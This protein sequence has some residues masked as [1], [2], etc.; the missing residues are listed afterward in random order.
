ME[1]DAIVVG[2]GPN[3][4]AAATELASAG[5]SVA[6]F[7]A[8]DTVGGGARSAE[9][10]LPGFTHDVCSAIHPLGVASPFFKS[11][12]LEQLGVEWIYPEFPVAHP[13]DNGEAAI[14]RRSVKET[15]E[16]L[17]EDRA[18]YVRLFEPMTAHAGVIMEEVLAPMHVPR[19]P[20]I[21]ASF[22]R[23]AVRAATELARAY[24]KGRQS[25]ALFAGLAAHAQMPLDRRP[26]AAY[27]LLLGMLGHSV[28][29]PLP[30][31]GSQQISNALAS[32]I[33]GLGGKVFTARPIES[34]D[35]LPPARAILC[36]ITPRQLIRIAGDRLD[37]SYSRKLLRYRYGPGV[38]KIDWALNAPI[39]WKNPEC[40][41]AGTVH[42][43]GTLEEIAGAEDA[44]GH[45]DHPRKPFVLVAQ[46][47]VFDSTRAP[48]GGHT[49]W[50]YCHVP[51]GS[52][53]DMTKNIENQIERF[54]P[55]FRDCVIAR[56]TINTAQLEAYNPNCVGGDINGGIQDLAQII[57]RPASAFHPYRTSIKGVYLCS[58][59]TPPGGGVHGMCG[60]HAA[61]AAL[62]DMKSRR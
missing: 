31:S 43:G 53:V 3:G 5:C 25:R 50:T 13:L 36:D 56:H 51:N 60:Y 38:F 10:T 55:G 8:R 32:H 26:T 30:K 61:R 47:S 9:I 35:E 34:L 54:A 1:F 7:E 14:L 28:G 27:G 4:L 44:V 15:A 40:R 41:R 39:P 42:V 62:H 11:L 37:A 46:P 20:F 6:V 18:P 57:W 12:G 24:F 29:W 19:H 52:T 49:A 23:Y 21:L 58:S 17:H 45:G 22:G 33:A 16:T 59:S 2:A 48:E